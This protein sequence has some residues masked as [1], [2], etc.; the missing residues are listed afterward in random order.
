[1]NTRQVKV[2]M[3]AF[4]DPETERLVTIPDGEYDSD[5]SLLETVFQFG[6]NEF[7][8]GPEKNTSP[9]VS[10]G[11]V[12]ELDDGRLFVCAAAGWDEI[13]QEQLAIYRQ[14]P[15]RDRSFCSLVLGKGRGEPL[16]E[17]S[18]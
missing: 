8:F 11:D 18:K 16:P 4:A 15:R 13:T 14:V 7:A 1:M 12:A 10:M 2:L 17:C 5:I 6:Q 3:L 9:S